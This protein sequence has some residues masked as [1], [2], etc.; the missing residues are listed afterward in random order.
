[1]FIDLVFC[2]WPPNNSGHTNHVID[3]CPEVMFGT[4]ELRRLEVGV[5]TCLFESR[6]PVLKSVVIGLVGV[7]TFAFH[8]SSPRWTAEF[9]SERLQILDERFFGNAVRTCATAGI[10]IGGG[11][12]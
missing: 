7:P 3:E 4:I 12:F 2:R 6:V 10:A 9:R 5:Q 11:A 1:M 8:I